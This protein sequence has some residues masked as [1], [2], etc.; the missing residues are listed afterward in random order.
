[1]VY[2]LRLLVNV[3]V[4]A[5]AYLCVLL[6]CKR[7]KISKIMTIYLLILYMF[8]VSLAYWLISPQDMQQTVI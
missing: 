4:I 6:P 3:L 2:L 8:L 7:K 5:G 1:M